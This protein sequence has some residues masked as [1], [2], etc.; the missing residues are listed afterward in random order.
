MVSGSSMSDPFALIRSIRSKKR[1]ADLNVGDYV[2]FLT[3]RAMSM[4]S[5]SILHANEMN[6]YPDL[7][8][9]A[10][11]RYYCAA[12]RSGRSGHRGK[13]PKPAEDP[14]EIELLCRRY[15][16][17]KRVAR[18]VLRTF[19]DEDRAEFLAT[20]TEGGIR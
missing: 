11:Y 12:I 20:V 13:W 1:D 18:Q 8:K 15:K 19:S 2:P 17:S 3:N 7:P 10:Q 14:P 16:Y 6:R 5:D 4:D 9:E